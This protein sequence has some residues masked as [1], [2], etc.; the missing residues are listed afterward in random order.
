MA[1]A[2]SR[3]IKMDSSRNPCG[4]MFVGSHRTCSFLT[5]MSSGRR[6]VRKLQVTRCA[7]AQ[8][9]EDLD[10]IVRIEQSQDGE[11]THVAVHNYGENLQPLLVLTEL[12]VL[13][14]TCRWVVVTT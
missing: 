1:D 11:K 13:S 5:F 12:V 3:T 4:L 6:P 8:I 10:K 2:G 7:P 14:R 9:A